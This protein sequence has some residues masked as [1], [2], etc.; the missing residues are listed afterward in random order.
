M[1]PQEN[2]ARQIDEHFERVL[3]PEVRNILGNPNFMY[4]IK[5]AEEFLLRVS[6]RLH[7]LHEVD[8]RALDTSAEYRRAVWHRIFYHG[9]DNPHFDHVKD[10]RMWHRLLQNGH[11]YT[12]NRLPVSEDAFRQVLAATS[13]LLQRIAAVNFRF[14][15]CYTHLNFMNEEVAYFHHMIPIY[16]AADFKDNDFD[17]GP[18][19]NFVTTE[20]MLEGNFPNMGQDPVHGNFV[21]FNQVWSNPVD[22]HFNVLFSPRAALY[23]ATFGLQLTL[24]QGLH[25]R[26]PDLLLSRPVLV[27]FRFGR[28]RL[29]Q[30]LQT[31]DFRAWNR[32][33]MDFLL[34]VAEQGGSLQ[35]RGEEMKTL[36]IE[37]FPTSWDHFR[38]RV[39]LERLHGAQGRGYFRY[40]HLPLRSN[41]M[42]DFDHTHFNDF[43]VLTNQMKAVRTSR[44]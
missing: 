18:R 29:H 26:L 30:A 27:S 25:P 22:E 17:F 1:N 36:L 9:L 6:V 42:R 13:P 20:K 31:G 24:E 28:T 39:F 32:R 40:M 37:R 41:Q 12:V 7:F 8:E 33:Y 15:M 10:P 4:F 44:L 11:G 14:P 38:T 21:T 23:F 3:V 34:K 19:V 16:A 5:R 2:F 43:W 35:L